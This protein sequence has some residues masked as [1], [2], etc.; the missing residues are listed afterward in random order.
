MGW[1]VGQG[2][3]QVEDWSRGAVNQE[4]VTKWLVKIGF[5]CHLFT[6]THLCHF[7]VHSDSPL[8]AGVSP[9]PTVI[10][11][12]RARAMQGPTHE[13]GAHSVTTGGA[14]QMACRRGS[15]ESLL[16][17]G[18]DKATCDMVGCP[19]LRGRQT[20]RAHPASA[21][22]LPGGFRQVASCPLVGLFLVSAVSEVS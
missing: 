7:G 22:D 11:D 16:R 20:C 19:G 10:T 2:C 9:L 3:Q 5:I 21:A 18:S 1:G 14:E 12:H 4:N 17:T 13:A 6:L 8:E 15:I